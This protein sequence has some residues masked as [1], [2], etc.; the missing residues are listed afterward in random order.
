[1]SLGQVKVDL[2]KLEGI[3]K[4]LKSKYKVR[5]GI[6]GNKAAQKHEDTELTN[7]ELGAI[8]EYGSYSAGIPKRSFLLEPLSKMWGAGIIK[9]SEKFAELL[10]ENRIYSFFRFLGFKGEEIVSDAF[11]TG[12]FGKWKPL[13]PET[14]KRRK[15]SKDP[16]PLTDTGQLARSITSEVYVDNKR[17]G[18]NSESN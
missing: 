7:Y 18:Q 15:K 5:V 3:E 13:K 17:K 11:S 14:I 9:S 8:H 6:L 1:M 12:G 4:A 16:K 2:S 10:A